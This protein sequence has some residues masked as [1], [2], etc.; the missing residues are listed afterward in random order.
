M[1]STSTELSLLAV[2]PAC[3]NWQ[4]QHVWLSHNVLQIS[5]RMNVNWRIFETNALFTSFNEKVR[6][7]RLGMKRNRVVNWQSLE[8]TK[9]FRNYLASIRSVFRSLLAQPWR[10]RGPSFQSPSANQYRNSLKAFLATAFEPIIIDTTT[11]ARILCPRLLKG[12]LEAES[13]ACRISESLP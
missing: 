4:N 1:T 11:N 10:Q 5:T 6:K 3:D 12:T 13:I 8:L 9:S 7:E 2:S